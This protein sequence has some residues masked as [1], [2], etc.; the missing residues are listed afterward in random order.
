MTQLPQWLLDEL[1]EPRKETTLIYEN[2]QYGIR[3]VNNHETFYSSLEEA[4]DSVDCKNTNLAFAKNIPDNNDGIFFG[5]IG[6]SGTGRLFMALTD[7]DHYD[8][9]VDDYEEFL[10]IAKEYE[11]DY[12]NFVLAYNF[13]DKHP[14]FWIRTKNEKTL[15]WLTDGHVNTHNGC[16]MLDMIVEDDG[17]HYWQIETGQHVQDSYTERYLDV[18]LT[19]TGLSAEEAFIELA[20]KIY[21]KFDMDGS[22]R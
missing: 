14:A 18:S 15:T 17:S 10:K 7:Q 2:E 5:E 4:Y 8:M 21:D 13:V 22:E 20:R 9:L 1:P 3:D 11:N 6:E 12:E 16:L 19:S